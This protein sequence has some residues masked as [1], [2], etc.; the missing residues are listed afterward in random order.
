MHYTYHTTHL[1]SLAV[2]GTTVE[3]V[4]TSQVTTHEGDGSDGGSIAQEVH[5]IHTTVDYLY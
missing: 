5:S 4:F 3:D 2:L 1:H